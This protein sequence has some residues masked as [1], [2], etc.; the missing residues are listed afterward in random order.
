M[1]LR[2]L[3]VIVLLTGAAVGCSTP[4]PDMRP[5]PEALG[6]S[7]GTSGGGTVGFSSAST[8]ASNADY[9]KIDAQ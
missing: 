7:S 5:P 9:W 8:E 6:A 1:K 3:F 2:H 4:D